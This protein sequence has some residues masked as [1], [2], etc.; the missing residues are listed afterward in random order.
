MLSAAPVG[1]PA[2]TAASR[3]ISHWPRHAARGAPR[4]GSQLNVTMRAKASGVEARLCLSSAGADSS[5]T[6]HADTNAHRSGGRADSV[7]RLSQYFNVPAV[8][9]WP[10]I[11]NRGI[12]EVPIDHSGGQALHFFV[13][14][15]KDTCPMAARSSGLPRGPGAQAAHRSGPSGSGGT[16]GR[17]GATSSRKSWWD[18]NIRWDEQVRHT[19]DQIT[20]MQA[21]SA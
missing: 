7:A 21:L 13:P 9:C 14:S 5:W 3:S 15:S 6:T 1:V 18:N 2:L 8:W 10:N 12:S 19:P 17:A 4:G 20:A 16:N 11:N